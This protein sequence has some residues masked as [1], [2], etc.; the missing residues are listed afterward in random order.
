MRKKTLQLLIIFCGLLLPVISSS[1]T[2]IDSKYGTDSA[3][4][5]RN[6]ALYSGF[7]KNG[8]YDDAI[9]HWNQVLTICPKNSR[10]I[11]SR[12]VQMFRHWIENET[13]IVRKEGLIDSLSLI[14]DM[15]I[16]Y[17]GK[18]QRYPEGWILGQKG[19]D[20]IKYRK[21]E[22]EIGYELLNRS[23]DLMVNQSK[24][25]V[26]LTL[27]QC[28]RQLFS[29]GLLSNEETIDLYSKLNDIADNNLKSK[30]GD[31][32]YTQ[33]KNGIEQ[34]F[35]GSGAANCDALIT[36][37]GPKLEENP[38]D[39]ELLKKV[40]QL[41]TRAECV[42]SEL[43]TIATESLYE[44]EPSSGA[45]R[46]MAMRFLSKENYDKAIEYYNYAIDLEE[47]P[48]AKAEYYYSLGQITFSIK[49]DYKK[50]R[51]YANKAIQ[52][53]P[54]YG[55]AFLLKGNCYA[56]SYKSFSK[57]DFENSTVFWVAVDNFVRAKSVDSEQT[58]K[59][60]ELIRK[61][62]QYFPPNDQIFFRTLEVGNSYTIGGWINERTTIRSRR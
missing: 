5:I 50:A 9:R 19:I 56:A 21:E 38:D 35:T 62:S 39:I 30:P 17:F 46:A 4:C 25:P 24:P 14:Y 26:I 57:D 28:A 44:L 6:V 51:D 36:L 59:A 3:L 54:E 23:V 55:V 34:H 37:F 7:Y 49:A 27:M 53:N 13:D 1:Q 20:M 33:A 60:N 16:K 32:G 29:M 31:A 8:N 15:R 22:V 43:F 10:N 18:D 41:L 40:T 45:A 42:D 52:L 61:Y 47:D 11:Y 2:T 48:I 12:G 58:D